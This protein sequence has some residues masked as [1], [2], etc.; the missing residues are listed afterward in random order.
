MSGTLTKDQVKTLPEK[1]GLKSPKLISITPDRPNIFLEKKK[2]V[3]SN[4]VMFVYED[5]FKQECL[6]LKSNPENYPVTIMYIPMFYMSCAI[7]FLRSLFGEQQITESC[8]SAVYANQ[9]D[10][11]MKA[12]LADLDRDSPKIRLVLSTS[13][14]GMGFD[15]PSVT[16]GG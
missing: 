7:M 4:D 12:T 6:D 13:V 3:K 11:V 10:D 8:Y 9:D 5:V 15:P 16:C 14:S 1:L 2:K